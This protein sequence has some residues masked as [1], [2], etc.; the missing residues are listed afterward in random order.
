MKSSSA[1]SAQ[2]MSSK[3]RITGST[4]D[5]RS[6]N[7]RHAEN[8]F[9]WSPGPWSSRPSSWAS[10]GSTNRRSV[11]SGIEVVHGRPELGGG[12]RG[13]LVLEDAGA[14]AHHLRER[15]ERDAVAVRQTA[16]SVPPRVVAR[17]VEVLL[18]L[19][20]EPGLADPT[21]ADHRDEARPTLVRGGVE[22]L[23]HQSELGVT[24]HERRLERR[25]GHHPSSEAHDADRPPQ[26]DGLRLPLQL[27]RTRPPRTR[28][29]PRSLASWPRRRR[30]RPGERPPGSARPCS[31]GRRRPCPAPRRRA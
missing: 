17:P 12:R 13:V 19:P 4:S 29:P 18:E 25:R 11:A 7:S 23:L 9:A 5:I 20:R 27:V 28:S 10:L 8:R 14:A 6:K 24:S 30:P 26:I 15:P 2:W 3:I 16:P 22:P 31:R 1:L 21:D